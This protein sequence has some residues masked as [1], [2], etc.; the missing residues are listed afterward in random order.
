M[1][2]SQSAYHENYNCETALVK[3]V[4]N[5]LWSMEEGNVTALMPLHL[6][7][8]FDAVGHSILLKILQKNGMEG[9]CLSWFDTYLSPKHCKVNVGL[10]HSSEHELQCSVPQ[11]I[12]AGPVTYLTYASTL[13]EVIPSDIPLHGFAGDH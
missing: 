8:A 1:P 11:G 5:M 13:Q 10:V 12:C 4:D 6:S 3:I 7:A 2:D 9:K